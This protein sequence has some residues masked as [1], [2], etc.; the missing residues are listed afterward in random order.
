V[1]LLNSR[2]P[3]R[4]PEWPLFWHLLVQLE[5]KN[6]V[7]AVGPPMCARWLEKHSPGQ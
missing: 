4:R 5:R 6:A 3:Q 2:A 7:K 1:D